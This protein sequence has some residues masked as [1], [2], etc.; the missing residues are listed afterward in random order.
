MTCVVLSQVCGGSA[1]DW[2]RVPLAELAG[3]IETAET[4][5]RREKEWQKSTK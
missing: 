4:K 5:L 1:L 2:M 3:W